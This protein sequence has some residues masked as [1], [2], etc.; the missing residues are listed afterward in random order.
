MLEQLDSVLDTEADDTTT[1]DDDAASQADADATDDPD[2]VVVTIGTTADAQRDPTL[3]RHIT[4]MVNTSY[5]QSL[6]E[7]L[8]PGGVYERTSVGDVMNR[9]QMGDDG[10]RA[11]RVLHLAWRRG[12]CVGVCSSTYQPPWCQQGCGHWGLVVA[13]VEHQ[14]TGV[15][16]A[17]VRAAEARLAGACEMI[18]IEYE[19]TPGD[20]YS[21]RLHAWYEERCLTLT[22]TL[23]RT[24]TRALTLTL[25][26]T[27]YEERCGFTCARGPP[28]TRGGTQFRKCHKPVPEAAQRVARR[29]RMLA[30]RAELVTEL[31]QLEAEMAAAGSEA[32]AVAG[33]ADGGAA[34]GAAMLGK[35]V[36]VRHLVITPI[37]GHA[38][39]V[40]P[41][42]P[43]PTL[44]RC[45]ACATGPS[46][47]GGAGACCSTTR[48]RG[49][50]PCGW[51]RR[52]GRSRRWARCCCC[53]PTTCGAWM[54][55]SRARTPRRTRRMGRRERTRRAT[56]T[57]TTRRARR[58]PCRM[59]G[60]GGR[61]GRSEGRRSR[62]SSVFSPPKF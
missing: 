39:P 27:R 56:S 19:Y 2:R 54:G 23:T 30:M 57:R 60:K 18:Q 43:T 6:K 5:T 51:S 62:Q 45:A 59:T 11:N 14:G 24:R 8:P 38:R 22:L 1:A 42:T 53:A 20:H 58:W 46:T 16:S 29:R 49:A 13:H 21:E 9:L 31:A 10:A 48:R 36:Q 7:Q 33:G 25:T 47:T 52:R 50:T 26:L 35:A 44:A 32:A 4:T 41:W 40:S 61:E 28:P 34:G 15:A 55:R 37:G 3:A 12:E 17:L